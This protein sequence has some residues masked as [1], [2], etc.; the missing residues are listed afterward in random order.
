MSSLNDKPRSRGSRFRF[1][2]LNASGVLP[3]TAIGGSGRLMSQLRHGSSFD[4]GASKVAS[5]Q[6]VDMRP[7]M[8]DRCWRA[9][10]RCRACRLGLKRSNRCALERTGRRRRSLPR[11]HIFAFQ[12]ICSYL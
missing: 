12:G 4:H 2:E 3:G 5:F 7:M 9:L 6:W 8:A 10:E 11:L 1:A